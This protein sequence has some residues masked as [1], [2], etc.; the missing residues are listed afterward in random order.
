MR[1]GG[2]Y[3]GES[4][5]R[6]IVTLLLSLLVTLLL[7]GTWFF[8]DMQTYLVYDK[9][10]V[11][12]VLPGTP[13]Y[14]AAETAAET[15]EDG[16]YL[17]E[18][19]LLADVEIV[20]DKTD[21]SQVAGTAAADLSPLRAHFVPAESITE[22]TLRS[23][24]YGLGEAYN[25]LVLE[26][27]DETGMLSYHSA[28]SAADS[29]AVNGSLELADYLRALKEKDI[30][31]VAALST[32][33]D[34]TM[35]VRNLPAAMKT[36]DGSLYVK[37]GQAWMDPY[38]ESVRSYLSA[39]ME[40]LAA[41]GFDEILFTGFQLPVDEDLRF[42]GEMT[43]MP[44]AVS[45]VSSLALYLRGRGDDLGLRVSVKA[46][47]AA[48]SETGG[49]CQDLTMLMKAFD[50]V[51]FDADYNYAGHLSA[52]EAVWQETG[53]GDPD[54]RLVPDATGLV[55]ERSCYIVR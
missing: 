40:D 20:V 12:L 8:I 46:E 15:E 52:L 27:K 21:Y 24:S 23:Y 9:E 35:A 16:S 47:N 43:E 44:D 26:L 22:G 37:D 5:Y 1:P 49:A 4:S 28:A 50:R 39:L 38:S 36:A 3:R 18:L 31:L 45:A 6:W 10:G 51:V 33:T 41:L 29:Y 42:S 14:A 11:R 48:F 7:V 34:A 55:P 19:P 25:A 54:L 13:E 30:Y 17:R 2:F 32:L 53:N